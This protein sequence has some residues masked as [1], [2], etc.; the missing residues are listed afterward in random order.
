MSTTPNPATI[1]YEQLMTLF[2]E[3][4][5][6]SQRDR[7]ESQRKWEE[8]RE[9]QKEAERKWEEYREQRKEYDRK[10]EEAERK[11]QQTREDMKEANQRH[12][13]LSDRIGDLIQAMVYGGIK[14]L[15][16]ELGYDFDVINQKYNFGNKELG[17]YGEVDLF[18]ENGELALLVEVKTNLSMKDVREHKERLEDFRRV[19]DVK[20]DKRRFLAAVGGGVIQDNVRDFALKQGMFVVQQSGENVEILVPKGKPKVW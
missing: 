17:I 20:N 4:R 6:Q 3:D 16:R 15:F 8:Y 11:W 2:L 18:L 5:Q 1:T 12:G 10:H 7:E 9:Q 19:A 14:R 13:K